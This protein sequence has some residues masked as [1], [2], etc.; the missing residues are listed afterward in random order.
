MFEFLGKALGR[1]ADFL[2]GAEYYSLPKE[3]R[4]RAVRAPCPWCGTINNY[5]MTDPNR[6]PFRCSQCG[7]VEPHR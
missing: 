3:K 1:A 5:D 6:G 2:V 7:Y 4:G